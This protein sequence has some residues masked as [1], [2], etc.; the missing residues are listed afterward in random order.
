MHVALDKDDFSAGVLNHGGFG[1][2]GHPAM[3]VDILG[4]ATGI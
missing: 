4:G 3:S 1:P 2:G